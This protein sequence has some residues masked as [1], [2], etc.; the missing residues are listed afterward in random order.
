MKPSEKQ[1]ETTHNVPDKK[2]KINQVPTTNL[3]NILD[4]HKINKENLEDYIHDAKEVYPNTHIFS[5]YIA[6]NDNN[7]TTAAIIHNCAGFISRS[8]AYDILNGTTN[9]HPSRDILLILCISAHMERKMIRRVLE[10]YNHREL[11]LKDPR[12]LI[13]STYINNKDYDLSAINDELYNYHL[14]LLP[15]T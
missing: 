5:D 10:T 3:L 14:P 13:I 1:I 2:M 8:Y 4:N 11:Y 15:A 7:I 9:K 6:D 12:D